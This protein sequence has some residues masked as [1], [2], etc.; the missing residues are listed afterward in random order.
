[1]IPRIPVAPDPAMTLDHSLYRLLPETS[2]EILPTAEEL[3]VFLASPRKPGGTELHRDDLVLIAER[4]AAI[5]EHL[6]ASGVALDEKLFYGVFAQARL[7]T[8]ELLSAIEHFKFYRDSLARIDLK[9]PVAFI[10]SAEEEI[11][12]LKPHKKDE[13][14]RIKRLQALIEE[15]RRDLESQK[16][17]WPA[18]SRA[19]AG[20]GRAIRD[21]FAAVQKRCEASIAMLVDLQVG[22]KAES[23]V[24]EDIKT[25]FKDQLRDYLQHGPVTKEY[26]ESMKETVARLS[27]KISVQLL[28]DIYAMTGL[29]ETIHDHAGQCRERLEPLIPKPGTVSGTHDLDKD[30]ELFTLME[31]ELLRLLSA[32]PLDFKPPQDVLDDAE[33]RQILVEKRRN[34]LDHLFNLLRSA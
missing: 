5:E 4:T 22:K 32:V 3:N 29:Y 11:A 16:K 6:R 20:A 27:K 33:H 24:I 25:H 31:Q 2:R 30:K 17:R 34:I 9:K 12:R 1:M 18:L 10:R 19:L 21:E 8:P 15:R 26:V 13:E 28:E 14:P 23:R 7:Y